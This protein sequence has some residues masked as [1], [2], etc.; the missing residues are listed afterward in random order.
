MKR[1]I[2]LA[3]MLLVAA[4]AVEAN[5]QSSQLVGKW[6]PKDV[7]TLLAH[8]H[9]VTKFTIAFDADGKGEIELEGDT[10]VELDDQYTLYLT[11][12][13]D[14]EFT[15]QLSGSTLSLSNIDTEMDLDNLTITPYSEENNQLIPMMKEAMLADYQ[16]HK[17]ELA[18]S[19]LDTMGVWS[20]RFID[21]NTLLLDND[22]YIRVR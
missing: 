12:E 11:I 19:F 20:V 15:W 1:V 17:E 3:V 21:N 10:K 13:I 5:A 18:S 8:S 2:T 22:T 14:I 16:E 9:E 7:S 4:F 6:K